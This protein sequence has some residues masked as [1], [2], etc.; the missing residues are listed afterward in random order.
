MNQAELK[1]A[2]DMWMKNP[3]S[4]SETYG[5]ISQ[6]KTSSVTSMDE[7]FSGA[8]SFNGDI[9]RW[10]TSSVTTMHRMFA[11]ATSFNGDISQWDTSSVSPIAV[12]ASAFRR[13][14]AVIF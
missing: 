11:D 5:D 14:T 3:R 6:W 4:A 12:R 7:L 8:T 2:V 9:S 1:Y 13:H 10:D